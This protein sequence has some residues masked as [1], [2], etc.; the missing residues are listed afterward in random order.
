MNHTLLI[1]FTC[2][3]RT[4]LAA[5]L[6][7]L[8]PA[9]RSHQYQP[10]PAG[11]VLALIAECESGVRFS[12]QSLLVAVEHR[13]RSDVIKWRGQAFD[14]P[15]IERIALMPEYHEGGWR[16]ECQTDQTSIT[17]FAAAVAA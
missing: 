7:A 9:T 11:I 14:M 10:Y 17:S 6:H 4:Y 15:T 8:Y 16:N 1:R 2:E 3:H 13:D 5:L 12:G